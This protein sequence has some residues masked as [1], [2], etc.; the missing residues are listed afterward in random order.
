MHFRKLII[1]TF[2]SVFLFS[3]SKDEL[4]DVEL[5]LNYYDKSIDLS[6]SIFI[7]SIYDSVFYINPITNDTTGIKLYIDLTY[8]TELF[9][10]DVFS[11]NINVT[12]GF[13]LNDDPYQLRK[14]S[15]T[16]KY[17]IQPGWDIVKNKTNAIK[18]K[19]RFIKDDSN[20]FR[21]GNASNEFLF[22][23]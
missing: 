22:K 14:E 6:N 7:N 1:I 13:Y 12:N 18:F 15:G 20:P 8:N 4:K 11:N 16:N 9:G 2:C 5:R 10:N 17:Y 23:L 19:F 21:L 3:C